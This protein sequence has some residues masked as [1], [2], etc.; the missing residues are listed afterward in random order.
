MTSAPQPI[1][2]T[3]V[4]DTPRVLLDIK[5]LTVYYG[6]ALALSRVSLQVS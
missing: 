5:G 6:K 1:E 4:P 3:A 2:M